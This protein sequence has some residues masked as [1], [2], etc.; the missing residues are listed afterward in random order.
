MVQEWNLQLANAGQ[1]LLMTSQTR[2][3]TEYLLL[4]DNVMVL[5]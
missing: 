5:D 2:S 1:A 4:T 3:R